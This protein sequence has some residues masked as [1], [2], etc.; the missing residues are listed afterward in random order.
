M[1]NEAFQHADQLVGSDGSG[2]LDC[3]ELAGVPVAYVEQLEDLGVGGPV[4]LEVHVPTPRWAA[5]G[6]RRPSGGRGAAALVFFFLHV[7]FNPPAHHSRCTRLRL[8][9][10]PPFGARGGR[11]PSQPVFR[12]AP[13]PF[14]RT[15]NRSGIARKA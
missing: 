7:T 15:A 8:T 12:P 6:R 5:R 4:E 2:D 14:G 10:Q 3:Q 11:A 1:G 13:P 9:L